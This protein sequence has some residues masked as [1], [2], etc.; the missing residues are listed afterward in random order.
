VLKRKAIVDVV[1]LAMLY[2]MRVV[3]GGAAIGVTVSEGLLGFSIFVFMS[4]ALLKRYVELSQR[5]K[6]SLPDPTNRG[7]KT[8]DLP[9][10]AALAAASAFNAITLF[11]LYLSSE[12]VHRLYRHPE[13]LWLICPILLY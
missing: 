10:I 12:V 3:A 6:L 9:I 11:A 2:T 13:F 5:M 4:L 7:Y 1:T 8:T